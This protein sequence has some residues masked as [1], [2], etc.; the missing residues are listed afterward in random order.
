MAVLYLFRFA[1]ARHVL[2]ADAETKVTLVYVTL[3]RYI[4]TIYNYLKTESLPSLKLNR[5]SKDI[6]TKLYTHENALKVN[7]SQAGKVRTSAYLLLC[8]HLRIRYYSIPFVTGTYPEEP[9]QKI[10]KIIFF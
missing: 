10:S 7:I 2:A 5:F 8:S 9:C 3:T 6:Y 4:A 1:C